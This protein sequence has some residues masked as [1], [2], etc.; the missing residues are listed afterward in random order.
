MSQSLQ[1]PNHHLIVIRGF[2]EPSAG[3]AKIAFDVADPDTVTKARTEFMQKLAAGYNAY[4]F[5]TGNEG[6]VIHEFDTKFERIVLT[7]RMAG[8]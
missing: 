8:G 1:T 5:L 6:E 4:G 3:D 2:H 7:P